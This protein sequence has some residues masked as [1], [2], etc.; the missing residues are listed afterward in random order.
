MIY[1][2]Q[3][4]TDLLKTKVITVKFTK[5]D[6]SIRTMKC[7]LKD[8]YITVPSKTSTISTKA[9]NDKMVTVWDIDKDSFR[10]FYVDSIISVDDSGFFEVAP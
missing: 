5:T 2:K 4:L 10:S 8:D 9:V 6:G 1:T 3:E 7:T